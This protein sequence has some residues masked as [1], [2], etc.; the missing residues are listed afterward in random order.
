MTFEKRH[1]NFIIAVLLCSTAIVRA[2]AKADDLTAQQDKAMS[3]WCT[4]SQPADNG[5]NDWVNLPEQSIHVVRASMQEQAKVSLTDRT[6][7]EM[8]EKS[9]IP[10][11]RDGETV[12]QAN[13]I[14]LVRAAAFYVS[15]KYELPKPAFRNLPFNVSY[16]SSRGMLLVTN[17]AL[18]YAGVTPTNL[19]LAVE[20]P[21]PISRSEAICLR[22]Q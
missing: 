7:V 16:S 8:A 2:P 13:H 20:S 10:Y 1:R 17:F 22:T 15:D 12:S 11:L 4:T 14:Y 6:I 9:I 3:L 19:A 18:G 21:S 5:P